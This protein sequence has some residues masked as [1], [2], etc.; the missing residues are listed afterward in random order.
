MKCAECD[1]DNPPHGCNWIKAGPSLAEALE[2]P[3]IKALVEALNEIGSISPLK[4]NCYPEDW[5]EQIKACPECQRYANH[6]VQQGICDDHRKPI[7]EQADHDRHEEK[8]LGYQASQIARDA[9][10]ALQTKEGEK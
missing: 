7:Y 1:C 6:P 3:E 5:R 10:A 4:K 2:L 9:L 8:I